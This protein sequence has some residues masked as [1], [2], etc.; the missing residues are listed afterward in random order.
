MNKAISINV[1]FPVSKQTRTF[2]SVRAVARMLSGTG[3]ASGGLRKTIE[4]QSFR[5][6]QTGKPGVVR[7]NLV[8]G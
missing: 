8:A 3:K 1:T 6:Y 4:Q 5:V 2:R 7:N